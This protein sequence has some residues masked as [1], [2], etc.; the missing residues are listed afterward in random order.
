[1]S[2]DFCDKLLPNKCVLTETLF[3]QGNTCVVLYLQMQFVIGL[4]HSKS[5]LYKN[6]CLNVGKYLRWK[7]ALNHDS[8]ERAFTSYFHHG[9]GIM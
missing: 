6:L 2:K 5:L 1:M 7:V 3:V 4:I 8:S 9:A